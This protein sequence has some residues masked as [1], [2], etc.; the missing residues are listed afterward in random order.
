[1]A[2]LGAEDP[3]HRLFDLRIFYDATDLHNFSS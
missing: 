3:N 1:M 2:S